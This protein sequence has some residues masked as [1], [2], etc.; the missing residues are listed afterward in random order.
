MRSAPTIPRTVFC[1]YCALPIPPATG[2]GRAR[3]RHRRCAALARAAKLADERRSLAP[4]A[5]RARV[6]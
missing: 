6:F 3:L 1:A 4:Y 5:R 2:R